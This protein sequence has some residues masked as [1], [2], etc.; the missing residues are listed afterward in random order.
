L[1]NSV[2]VSSTKK[3]NIISIVNGVITLANT[4]A[5]LTVGDELTIEI[6][7]DNVAKQGTDPSVTLTSVDEKIDDF[8]DTFDADMAL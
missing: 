7:I 2:L 8:Y 6:D 4:T 1:I 3:G 5:A